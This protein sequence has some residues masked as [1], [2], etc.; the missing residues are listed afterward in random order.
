[1]DLITEQKALRRKLFDGH[2]R[3]TIA[4]MVERSNRELDF[5]PARDPQPKGP[6]IRS[7]PLLSE[8]A[9]EAG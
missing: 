7:Y 2:R 6:A 3:R 1:M 9:P 5:E 8:R 4:A